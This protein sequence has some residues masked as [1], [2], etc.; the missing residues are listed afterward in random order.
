M[1]GDAD[2]YVNIGDLLD[3]NLAAPPHPEVGIRRDGVGL[4][5]RGMVNTIFGE[6]ESGKSWVALAA[7]ADELFA[8][9]SVLIVD[10]DHNG[11]ASIVAR[12]LSMGVNGDL[13]RDRARFRYTVPEDADMIRAVVRNATTWKPTV[14]IVDSI[15]ELL[16]LFGASS[17]SADDFTRVN[18]VTMQPLAD[19]GACVIA[20]DHVSKGAESSAF[21][22][23]GTIAKKRAIGGASLRCKIATPFAPGHGGAAYLAISK[24]RHGGL[25]ENCPTGTGDREPLAATFRLTPLDDGSLSWAFHV[26]SDAGP[27]HSSRLTGLASDLAELDQLQPPPASQRD[28]KTRKRWGADRAQAAWKAWSSTRSSD[29]FLV[30]PLRGGGTEEHAI[31]VPEEQQERSRN[32][33]TLQP[34][35]A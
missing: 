21:G 3:G 12:F 15:G 23:T 8:G 31:P 22:A 26:P 30:P 28:V 1:S 2:P 11:A 29:A 9:G 32:T 34:V 17:N 27:G 24:D 20:I 5:Y 33:G 10:L 14:V 35:D 4:F 19:A 13:L 16:P 18:S 6:P 7:A 25:R